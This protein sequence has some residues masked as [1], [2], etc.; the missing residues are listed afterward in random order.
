[1]VIPTPFSVSSSV[2]QSYH[3]TIANPAF[4]D[5]MQS[6]L[7]SEFTT[8]EDAD[9]A[10]EAFLI[11]SKEQLT[12]GEIAKIRDSTGNHGMAGT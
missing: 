10:F 9:N 5:K 8:K 7:T 6:F 4:W 2:R 1:M 3:Q 12:A 11:A